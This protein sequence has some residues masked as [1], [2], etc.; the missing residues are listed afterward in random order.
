MTVTTM[1]AVVLDEPGPPENLQIRTDFPR[2]TPHKGEV[3]IRV[4]ACGL[5]RSEMF[6]R[7]GHSPSVT[8]PRILGIEA[9]GVVAACPSHEFPIGAV[10]ATA[11]G[12]MGR[13]WDGGYAEYV[14]APISQIVQLEGLEEDGVDWKILGALP[15]M[16]QTAWGSLFKSLQIKAGE[17][18]LIRGGT[19]SVGL[20]AASLAK[21]HGVRIVATTRNAESVEM[22]KENGADEVI[23]DTGAIEGRVRERYPEGIDKVLELV[24]VVTLKDS[25]ACAKLGGVVCVTGIAGNRWTLDNLN[26]MEYIPTGVYLTVYSGGVAELRQ[27]PLADILK[28]ITKGELK[29]AIGKVFKLVDIVEAHRVMEAGKAGGKIVITM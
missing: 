20:A 16:M 26:P 5:N 19:T 12:G 18:L 14:C 28:Q 17:T 23:I 25:L 27:T 7:Q 6:T 4:K 22:L 2:P 13:E 11:M 9:V 10:V 8:F 24:G 3:L 29:L 1:K 15:E 21:S